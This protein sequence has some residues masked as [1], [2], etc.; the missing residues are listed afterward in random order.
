MTTLTNYQTF[1][2]HVNMLNKVLLLSY[3]YM[4]QISASQYDN[5]GVLPFSAGWSWHIG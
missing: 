5:K 1:I 2:V 3:F 4:P